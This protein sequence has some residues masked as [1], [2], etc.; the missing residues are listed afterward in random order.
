MSAQPPPPSTASSRWLRPSTA[1]LLTLVGAGIVVATGSRLWASSTVT[2]TGLGTTA[3]AVTGS[4]AVGPL[5]ALVLAAVAGVLAAATA[6][7][8]GRVI[9]VVVL[10]A[11]TVTDLALVVIFLLDP[12]QA[13]GRVAAEAMGRT[14]TLPVSPTA[15]VWPWVALAGL[16]FMLAAA[17]VAALGA[18]G[19]RGLSTRYEAGTADQAS[20]GPRGERTSSDWDRLSAGEDPTAEPPTR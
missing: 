12:A 17:V 6:G 11:A 13:V 8:V 10:A 9:G 1:V 14:G 15:T 16:G 18:R 5:V 3:A 19:W 20:T 7:R 2:D 4:Q